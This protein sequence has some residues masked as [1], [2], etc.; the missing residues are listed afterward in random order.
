[1][2]LEVSDIIVCGH[3][4]CGAMK[5]AMGPQMLLTMPHVSNW[6]SYSGAAL[7]KVKARHPDDWQE[8]L[9]EMTKENVVMQLKHLETHPSV[10]SKLAVGSVRMHGWLYD[11]PKGEMLCFDPRTDDFLPFEARYADYLHG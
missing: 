9:M 5:A 2:V 11:I 10:A 8:R 6:L 7:A 4:D 1:M 3:T